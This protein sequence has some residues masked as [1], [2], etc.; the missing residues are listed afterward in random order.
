MKLNNVNS[1]SKLETFEEI[2]K[3]KG[4]DIKNYRTVELT[5]N[6]GKYWQ[7]QHLDTYMFKGKPISEWSEFD[8]SGINMLPTA[9]SQKLANE[10]LDDYYV[11]NLNYEKASYKREI[12]ALKRANKPISQAVFDSYK[13]IKMNKKYAAQDK[14]D[15]KEDELAEKEMDNVDVV[16]TPKTTQ[17]LS[18]NKH[19]SSMPYFLVGLGI[20]SLS[21]QKTIN[22][23][24]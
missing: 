23:N 15:A 5:G 2:Y 7:V 17:T 22:V 14:V 10:A 1:P 11:H 21:Y 16:K 3:N 6:R 18:A 19:K 13:N 24:K 4:L 20:L 12:N 8:N 9:V